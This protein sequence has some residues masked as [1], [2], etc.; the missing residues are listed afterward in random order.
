MDQQEKAILIRSKIKD[1]A[2]LQQWDEFSQTKLRDVLDHQTMGSYEMPPAELMTASQDDPLKLG[3]DLDVF[4]DDEDP[5]DAHHNNQFDHFTHFPM[6][7]HQEIHRVI[8]S[9]EFLFHDI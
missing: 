9:L 4:E 7:K 8:C 2:L 6:T 1:Q 3:V 5:L